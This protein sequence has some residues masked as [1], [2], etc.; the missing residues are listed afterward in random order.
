MGKALFLA[1]DHS[2]IINGKLI[3]DDGGLSFHLGIGQ[4]F[5]LES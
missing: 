2:A 5:L 4:V 3:V 1:N